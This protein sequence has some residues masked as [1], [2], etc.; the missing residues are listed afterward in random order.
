MYEPSEP[1]RDSTEESVQRTMMSLTINDNFIVT[2]G[3]NFTIMRY[4][5]RTEITLYTRETRTTSIEEIMDH[6]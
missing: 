6:G 4:V 2:R 1:L 5:T 3:K